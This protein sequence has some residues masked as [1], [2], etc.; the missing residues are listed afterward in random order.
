MESQ[1]ERNGNVQGMAQVDRL[2]NEIQATIAS[3]NEVSRDIE[4][5]QN[6]FVSNENIFKT[7]REYT[8]KI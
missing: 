4:K 6:D 2:R 8:G 7:T 5:I 3:V 1:H